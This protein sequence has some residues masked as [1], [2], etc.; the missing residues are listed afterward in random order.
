MVISSKSGPIAKLISRPPISITYVVI[1]PEK[2]GQ[3]AGVI[4]DGNL[5]GI[6]VFA[7][8]KHAFEELSTSPEVAIVGITPSGGLLIPELL[9]FIEEAIE[10]GLD[11]VNGLHEFLEEKPHLLKRLV[12]GE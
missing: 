3:D 6:P 7:S 11:I 2:S 8:S 4:V 10:A 5:R 1:D 12:V 9:N